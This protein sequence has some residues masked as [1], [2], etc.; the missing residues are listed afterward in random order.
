MDGLQCIKII[1][2]TPL[3]IEN[4]VSYRIIHG[5][6]LGKPGSVRVDAFCGASL[7]IN[8]RLVP[9]GSRILDFETLQEIAILS[10][11]TLLADKITSLAVGTVGVGGGRHTEIVK[12]IYDVASLL[13]RANA[14][15]IKT[16]HDS[17]RELTG[18]K[19][20]CFR[21][22]PPYTVSGV[23]TSVIRTL[24]SLASGYQGT[25][26]AKHAQTLQGLSGELSLQALSIQ[27]ICPYCRCDLGAY[28]CHVPPNMYGECSILK[29]R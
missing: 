21:H 2:K 5:S 10:R 13:R 8:T 3:P 9:S 17:Y 6:C 20:D 25:C 4:L 22:D 12:Q 16:A 15:D 24:Q 11:G 29:G 1:P 19:V 7:H 14:G 28:L 26:G 18:F 27:G 23:T